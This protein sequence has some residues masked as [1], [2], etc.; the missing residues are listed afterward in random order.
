MPR[1][2]ISEVIMHDGDAKKERAKAEKRIVKVKAKA[3]KELTNSKGGFALF[4]MKYDKK[5]RV[6]GVQQIVAGA[7]DLPDTVKLMDAMQSTAEQLGQGIL[8][9]MAQ[10]MGMPEEDLALDVLN[11]EKKGK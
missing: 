6:V 8:R 3:V 11:K 2:E 9:G 7:M 1:K 5:G 10:A 4:Y